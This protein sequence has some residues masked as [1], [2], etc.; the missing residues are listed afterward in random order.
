MQCYQ[1]GTQVVYRLKAPPAADMIHPH[2]SASTNQSF[3]QDR[4]LLQTLT[5]TLHL[6][7]MHTFAFSSH[8]K[9]HT[10]DSCHNTLAVARKPHLSWP[11]WPVDWLV[12]PQ[13]LRDFGPIHFPGLLADHGQVLMEFVSAFGVLHDV[14]SLFFSFC[15]GNSIIPSDFK[16]FLCSNCFNLSVVFC[17]VSI[18]GT[19]VGVYRLYLETRPPKIQR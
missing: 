8:Q 2:P 14:G 18:S 10:F 3:P 4:C 6:H 12:I 7:I 11:F 13:Q 1:Q 9:S 15:V 5:E 19:M 17:Y 16:L